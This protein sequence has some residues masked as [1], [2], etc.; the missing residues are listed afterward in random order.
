MFLGFPRYAGPG[1]L[2]GGF[3][4]SYFAPP[5]GGEP[6]PNTGEGVYFNGVNQ[7][8]T[9][10]T[11]IVPVSAD[12]TFS[13]EYN[14]PTNSSSATLY[15]ANGGVFFITVTRV[16][17]S[18]GLFRTRCN[19]RGPSDS[20]TVSVV[21][22][23]TPEIPRG[24]WYKLTV[25]KV[26]LTYTIG[27]DGNGSTGETIATIVDTPTITPRIAFNGTA[28]TK[29]S[30]RNLRVQSSAG[31]YYYLCDEGTGLTLNDNG[32]NANHATLSGTVPFWL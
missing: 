19:F 23:I 11:A 25:T 9:L 18:P 20:G 28:Y 26:D 17:Y 21:H 3:H 6:A 27:L 12:Y 16:E 22:S 29:H 31:D 15:S 8:A 13:V 5:G 7:L 10:P 1:G 14:Q 2:I 30:M 24:V 4:S 32:P